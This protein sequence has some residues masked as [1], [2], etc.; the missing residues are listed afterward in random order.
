MAD[1]VSK[2]PK[3]A[4]D[5]EIKQ[6]NDRRRK[7]IEQFLKLPTE[8]IRA[9]IA[10]T[11]DAAVGRALTPPAGEMLYVRK[12][13]LISPADRK[14]YNSLIY[15]LATPTYGFGFYFDPKNNPAERFKETQAKLKVI[16]R[17]GSDYLR[18]AVGKAAAWA[19]V[20]AELLAAVLQNENNPGASGFDQ[21]GQAAE[22]S[23]QELIGS[24]STGF[25]NVKPQTLKSVKELFKTYYKTS[26]LGPGVQNADQ[27]DNAETDIYHAAA[28]LRDGLNKAWSAGT[29]SLNTEQFK[30]YLYY[31][32]FGGTVSAEVAVR[33]MGHYNGMGDGAKTYGETGLRRI[34][35]QPLHFLPPR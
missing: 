14:E 28:A 30:K 26:I 32:Y 16:F 18:A 3:F 22:R 31:P 11:L 10:C 27:N 4:T 34:Q 9:A 19:C 8:Q 1:E 23:L 29:R 17:R 21:A 20:P 2:D 24:G 6:E 33:A 13:W 12:S 25:G 15:S 35:K 5:D 7:S